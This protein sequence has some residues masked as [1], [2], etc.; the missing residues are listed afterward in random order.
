MTQALS[1]E[2]A[3]QLQESLSLVQ[4]IKSQEE[5]RQVFARL[6]DSLEGSP[7][8]LAVVDALWQEVISARRSA[9]FW[10]EISNVEKDMAERL[11]QNNVQLQQNY[12]R[13]M[14]EQ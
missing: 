2:Q 14:Q 10:Q 11:A 1:Q 8:V 7:A 12:L 9:A 4:T 3:T 5:A 13:L 6:R